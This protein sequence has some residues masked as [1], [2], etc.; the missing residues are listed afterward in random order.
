[1]LWTWWVDA[2][3]LLTSSLVEARMSMKEQLRQISGP[4]ALMKVGARLQKTPLAWKA[5]ALGLRAVSQPRRSGQIRRYL[6]SNPVRR[7][8][9]GAGRHVDEGW[10]SADLIPLSRGVVYMNASKPLPLPD[11]SFDFILC[12]HM[13]EHVDLADA[14]SLLGEFH[15]ILRPGGVLRLATPK[16]ERLLQ[17]TTNGPK[18]EDATWYIATLN[19][20]LPGVP[21]DDAD[22]PVYMLNRLMHDWGH[23]FLYDEPTLT[24]LLRDAGFTGVSRCEPGVSIHTDLTG[25]DRHHEEVGE[26]INEIDTLI[27]EADVAD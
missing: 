14:T 16:L 19:S 1:L 17:M 22:N 7:L 11:A 4:D 10:M 12:E 25:I 21:P 9:L 15:R 13:I 24:K 27:L 3:W 26:R 2:V 23:R 6:R 5:A 8:R 18:D 20:G